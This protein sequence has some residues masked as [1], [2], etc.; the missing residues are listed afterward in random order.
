MI[1][2]LSGKI[3]SSVFVRLHTHICYGY[4]KPLNI[5]KTSLYHFN[6]FHNTTAVVSE[7]CML[8]NLCLEEYL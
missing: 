4:F 6:R 1:S 7:T 2:I 3:I 8:R 5:S